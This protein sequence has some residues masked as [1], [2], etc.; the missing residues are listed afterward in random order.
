LP[1]APAS[2]SS[3]RAHGLHDTA[4]RAF[5]GAWSAHSYLLQGRNCM[6]RYE[7]LFQRASRTP[8]ASGVKLPRRSI[9]TGSGTGSWTIR[10]SRSTAGSPAGEM[11]TC[12]NA[13]DRHVKG[14]RA[15]QVAMIYDSPVTSTLQKF[16]YRELL[17][18]V[19]GSPGPEGPGR[20]KGTTV[21]IYM[22]MI[23]RPSLPCWPAR[24]WERSTPWSS[25]D[26]RPTSSPSGS[27]THG[28]RS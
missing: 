23:P 21:I 26:S 20:R 22:P 13:L 8:R 7:E 25:A 3:R 1:E 28:P 5:Q 17:D 27:T 2:T 4:D 16:T 18:Q 14:G 6:G 15:D 24:A 12:Y 19:S 10:R 11:N 9:G